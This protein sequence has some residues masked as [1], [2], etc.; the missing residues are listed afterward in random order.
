MKTIWVIEDD[1]FQRETICE[2]IKT[3]LKCNVVELAT[4]YEF[5]QELERLT[6][7]LPDFLVLDIMLPW[8]KLMRKMP[9]EPQ[10]VIKNGFYRAGIRCEKLF[11]SREEL[12]HIPIIIYTNLNN[13]DIQ[14]DLKNA[15][16]HTHY[17]GKSSEVNQLVD[18]IYKLMMDV[19]YD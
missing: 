9:P 3:K 16:E 11:R 5:S 4:E 6:N 8:T 12:K 18:K 7:S 17:L 10:E 19:Q 2:A 14:D 15:S 1:Y 13:D